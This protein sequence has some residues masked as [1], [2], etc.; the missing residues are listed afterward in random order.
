MIADH[1]PTFPTMKV[2][3]SGAPQIIDGLGECIVRKLVDPQTMDTCTV[4]DYRGGYTVEFRGQHSSYKP[5]GLP[6]EL[7]RA[8]NLGA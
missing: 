7:A 6:T 1:T 4:I 2:L 8:L 3:S 5:L